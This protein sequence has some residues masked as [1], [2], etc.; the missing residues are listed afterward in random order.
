M[1]HQTQRV[2]A[3]AQ[4]GVFGDEDGLGL[5]VALPRL[6]GDRENAVVHQAAV[7]HRLGQIALDEADLEHAAVGQWNPLGER[8]LDAMLVEVAG[9]L[10]GVATQLA[11][12]LLELVELFDDV[13]RNDDRVV[14]EAVDRPRVVQQ[15]VGVENEVLPRQTC[16]PDSKEW[17]A[18]HDI[19]APTSVRNIANCHRL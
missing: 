12:V 15:N 9:D 18:A 5:R 19:T 6:D 14:I 11:H 8:A 7:G 1:C 17:S 16:P 2:G 13:D 4:V 10:A 3:N